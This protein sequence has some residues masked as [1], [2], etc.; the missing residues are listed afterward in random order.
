MTTSTPEKG[1]RNSK[2]NSQPGSPSVVITQEL[3]AGKRALASRFPISKIL[4]DNGLSIDGQPEQK[5]AKSTPAAKKKRKSVDSTTPGVMKKGEKS[6]VPQSALES[7]ETSKKDPAKK[8]VHGVEDKPADVGTE[9]TPTKTPTKKKAVDGTAASK[10]GQTEVKMKKTP[11]K[12]EKKKRKSV[13][14]TTPGVAKEVEKSAK[15][16]GKKKKHARVEN[17]ETIEPMQ[18]DEALAPKK[19]LSEKGA[20]TPEATPAKQDRVKTPKK[21]AKKKKNV[22]QTTA[23]DVAQTE[24][25]S[26]K[27]PKITGKKGG[28][29]TPQAMKTPTEA[30]KTPKKS[31]KKNK[32]KAAETA[33]A[34]KN[35]EAPQSEVA[36]TPVAGTTKDAKTPETQSK[37]SEEGKIAK[38]VGGKEGKKRSAPAETGKA[39]KK[40]RASHAKNDTTQDEGAK[41]VTFAEKVV[42]QEPTAESGLA[43]LRAAR[44]KGRKQTG[45]SKT[46]TATTPATDEATEDDGEPRVVY[47]GHIPH[48]FYEK[49]MRLYFSQF[50]DVGRV[51][52]SRSKKSANSRGYAFVEFNEAVAAAKA[53]EAMDGYM[54]HS[55]RLKAALV[56]PSQVHANLFKGAQRR[57][58]C[59]NHSAKARRQRIAKS[60]D[61]KVLAKRQSAVQKRHMRRLQR[62]KEAGVQYKLPVLVE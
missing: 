21:S 25:E 32:K 2:S 35:A 51:R 55:R 9:K 54:M 47:V 59:E 4:A 36:G 7:K 44:R 40:N 31:A 23:S 14:S 24:N 38:A 22:A 15:I 18:I 34:D 49:E 5:M 17:V 27:T 1:K 46:N 57:F 37:T 58:V 42:Q 53:A 6:E 61:P 20:V 62:L 10:D 19:V 13:D 28:S 29:T 11:K 3:T 52:L 26:K 56:P 12:S 60:N 43:A 41:K 50:G 45:K 39:R 48:G 8:N 16:S 30:A 33:D